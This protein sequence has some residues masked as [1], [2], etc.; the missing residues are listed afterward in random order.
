MITKSATDIAKLRVARA[1][2]GGDKGKGSRRGEGELVGSFVPHRIITPRAVTINGK[3]RTKIRYA[4][5]SHDWT[6]S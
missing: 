1:W 5:Y 3:K 2:R 4:L 6:E